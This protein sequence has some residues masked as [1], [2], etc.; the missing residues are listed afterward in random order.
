MAESKYDLKTSRM[1]FEVFGEIVQYSEDPISVKELSTHL[2][3]TR[4]VVSEQIRTLKLNDLVN[5]EIDGKNKYFS[6]NEKGLLKLAKPDNK[7]D[8]LKYY[9]FA[10]AV[11][12][13]F[14]QFVEKSKSRS[15]VE[16]EFLDKTK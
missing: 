2:S 16:N 6:V 3:K 8:F 1:V 4:A 10:V 5:E 14:G 7:E 11:S 13:T 9:K 15:V 12:R